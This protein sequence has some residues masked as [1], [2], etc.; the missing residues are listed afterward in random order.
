ME[1]MWEGCEGLDVTDA[2]LAGAS[3]SAACALCQ[4]GSY[5]SGSGEWMCMGASTAR[6]G[7][8]SLF[9]ESLDAYLCF[10]EGA[11]DHG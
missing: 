8:L 3:S 5:W 10:W 4:A 9:V 2:M 6:E 7:V 1:G 11:R